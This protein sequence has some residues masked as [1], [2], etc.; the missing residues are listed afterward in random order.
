MN[1]KISTKVKQD[2]ETVF[3]GFDVHLFKEL[4]PPLVGLEVLRFDGCKTGDEVHVKINTFGV[5]QLW[6]SL[7]TANF[8]DAK[9]IYFV[10]EGSLLPRPLKYW[11]HKHEIAKFIENSIIID[12]ITYRTGN[13]LLDLLIFPLFYMQ[14][15]FRKGI[16][17]RYFREIEN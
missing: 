7:I 3:A 10:D 13:V 2:Y 11:K 12:N 6:K 4:K 5:K 16:Y 14:F 17:K 15:Y 8:K 9:S 1:F